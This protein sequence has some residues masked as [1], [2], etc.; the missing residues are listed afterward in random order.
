MSSGLPRVSSEWFGVCPSDPV[1]PFCKSSA[2]QLLAHFLRLALSFGKKLVCL[3]MVSRPSITANL[4]FLIFSLRLGLGT[5]QLNAHFSLNF[6]ET[7][8]YRDCEKWAPADEI[9]SHHCVCPVLII[10]GLCFEPIFI[11]LVFFVRRAPAR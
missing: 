8:L 2:F 5:L 1:C 11:V 9:R 7:T 3:S 4:P 10:F 6:R